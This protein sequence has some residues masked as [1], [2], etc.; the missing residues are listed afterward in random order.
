MSKRVMTVA[1]GQQ[2]Q[3]LSWFEGTS[4][5]SIDAT[6]R[7]LFGIG[8]SSRYRIFGFV[9]SRS[10]LFSFSLLLKDAE[11]DTVVISATIPSAQRFTLQVIELPVPNL[12]TLQ[13]MIH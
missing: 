8:P 4:D 12:D 13:V 10:L 5:T 11:G 6:L 2:T 1:W 7:S 9:F 3:R